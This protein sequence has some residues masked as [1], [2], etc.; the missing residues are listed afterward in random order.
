MTDTQDIMKK[1]LKH[2]IHKAGVSKGSHFDVASV[3]AKHMQTKIVYDSKDNLWYIFNAST[4]TWARDEGKIY[5][6]RILATDI[7]ALFE[8][9]DVEERYFKIDIIC[10]NFNDIYG[11]IAKKLKN[12]NYENKIIKM[13]KCFCTECDFKNKN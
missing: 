3:V 2:L 5:L 12:I 6:Y 11:K 9:R 1:S 7:S 8:E 13:L 4:N 10:K